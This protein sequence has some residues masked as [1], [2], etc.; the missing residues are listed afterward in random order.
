MAPLFSTML[1]YFIL[2]LYGEFSEYLEVRYTSRLLLYGLSANLAILHYFPPDI[3][4]GLLSA[5]VLFVTLIYISITTSIVWL[6]KFMMLPI[7]ILLV[8]YTIAYAEP[9]DLIAIVPD[10]YLVYSDKV[11]REGFIFMLGFLSWMHG[12]R[13][14]KLNFTAMFLYVAEYSIT[15]ER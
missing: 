6:S 15:M 8:N 2:F 10:W 11:F 3:Y 14:E 13:D 1:L 7:C 9:A 12:S 5:I 4:S